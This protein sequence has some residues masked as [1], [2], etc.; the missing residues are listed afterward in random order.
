MSADIRGHCLRTQRRH[1]KKGCAGVRR[2]QKQK[3]SPFTKPRKAKRHI[4]CLLLNLR[5][6]KYLTAW[7]FLFSLAILFRSLQSRSGSSAR[8]C[9][10]LLS[11]SRISLQHHSFRHSPGLVYHRLFA[12]IH[13]S[14]VLSSH[15]P[16]SEA[17]PFGNYRL[18]CSFSLLSLFHLFAALH[19]C[20][21][22][23]AFSFS[24]MIAKGFPSS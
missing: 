19:Y 20:T 11:S 2:P 24:V 21:A 12:N 1:R 9:R 14:V 17:C 5:K 6:R 8:N 3:T 10:N 7:R 13:L 16:R 23:S 18:I 4:N 15:R 22:L